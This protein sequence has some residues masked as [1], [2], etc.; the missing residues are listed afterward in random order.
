MGRSSSTGQLPVDSFGYI[1]SFVG[2]STFKLGQGQNLGC[3][4]HLSWG[5]QT[6]KAGLPLT[7]ADKS[8]DR[9]HTAAQYGRPDSING[10]INPP[11]LYLPM[12]RHTL[13][14]LAAELGQVIPKH[15]R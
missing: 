8:I 6:K 3:N 5:I 4:I 12:L 2:V 9:I 14:P 13:Q 11:K 7:K 15:L 10:R 1:E